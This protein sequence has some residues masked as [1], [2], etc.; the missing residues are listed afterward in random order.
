MGIDVGLLLG[1][2]GVPLFMRAKRTRKPVHQALP[3]LLEAAYFVVPLV[4]G[5]ATPGQRAAG[6]K[7]VDIESGGCPGWTRSAIR[8]AAW[9]GPGLVMRTVTRP[10]FRAKWKEVNR[11][12]NERLDQVEDPDDTDESDESDESD[13][14]QEAARLR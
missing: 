6:L 10:I 4:L 1:T 5:G 13:E 3:V 11:R 12:V 9:A 2:V 14:W 7:V 8:W